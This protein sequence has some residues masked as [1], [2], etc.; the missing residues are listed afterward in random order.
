LPCCMM[1]CRR[2][3]Q[4]SIQILRLRKSNC[5]NRPTQFRI[6][7]MN[8]PLCSIPWLASLTK[9]STKEYFFLKILFQFP[10]NAV[11]PILPH[12]IG[13]FDDIYFFVAHSLRFYIRN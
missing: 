10:K 9:V 4:P 12:L 11:I 6:C 5:A 2:A 13:I 3:A 1:K 7:V 8:I